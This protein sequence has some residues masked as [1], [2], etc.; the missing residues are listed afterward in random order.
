MRLGG[1]EKDLGGA[2]PAGGDI[3]GEDWVL[4]GFVLEGGDGASET[5][6]S[7]LEEAL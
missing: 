3:V 6:V 1:T 4:D 5:K 2:V 7:D